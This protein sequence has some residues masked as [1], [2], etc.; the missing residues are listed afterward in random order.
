MK[1]IGNFAKDPTKQG[2]MSQPDRYFAKVRDYSKMKDIM[3]TE[4]HCPLL[5]MS[6]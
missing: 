3:V 6:I 2:L 1:L 5:A 4:R